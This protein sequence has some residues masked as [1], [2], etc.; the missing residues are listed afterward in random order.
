MR[1]LGGPF[2]SLKSK[3]VS[4]GADKDAYFNPSK[5]LNQ[6]HHPVFEL[7]HGAKRLHLD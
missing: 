5:E 2:C 4:E 6:L 7:A 1:A 3:T